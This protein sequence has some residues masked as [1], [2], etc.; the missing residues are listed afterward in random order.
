MSRKFPIL[1]MLAILSISFTLEKNIDKYLEDMKEFNLTVPEMDK[2]LFC[3]SLS[4]QKMNQDN[5]KIMEIK[6]RINDTIVK[7]QLEDKIRSILIEYC[8]KKVEDKVFSEFFQNLTYIKEV[9]WKKD[10]EQYFE[11]NYQD[12]KE[13]KDFELNLNE[14]LISYEHHKLYDMFMKKTADEREALQKERKRVRI[15]DVD[16]ENIPGYVKMIL[17]LVVFGLLFGCIFWY[18]GSLGKS[19]KIEKKKKK[20][21]K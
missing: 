4:E 20:K 6:N 8:I 13:K 12:F 7:E 2:M 5:S 1:I 11:I 14:R 3:S 16:L 10:Y 18:L 9:I 17:F 19:Q 15:A 21:T